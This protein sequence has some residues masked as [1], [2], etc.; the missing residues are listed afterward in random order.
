ML[1]IFPSILFQE[2]NLIHNNNNNKHF[3]HG[4]FLR[5]TDI[6]QFKSNNYLHKLSFVVFVQCI[7]VDWSQN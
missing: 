6:E 1:N 4:I 2:I 3:C 5:K 7:M